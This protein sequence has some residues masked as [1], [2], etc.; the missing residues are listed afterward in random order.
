MSLDKFLS[1]GENL[2]VKAGGSILT[3]TE[4]Y[5][6]LAHKI[7]QFLRNY[8]GRLYVVVSAMKNRT[9]ELRVDIAGRNADLLNI[10][11][12][13]TGHESTEYFDQPHIARYLINGEFES[14]ERLEQELRKIGIS[15]YRISQGMNCPIVANDS[16]LNAKID[17]EESKKKA[18]ELFEK[19]EQRVMIVPGF[20]AQDK[21]GLVRLLGRNSSD[22]V[23]AMMGR[24]DAKVGLVVYL[25]DIDGIFENYGT[26]EQ[27][28]VHRMTVDKF[29]K[30]N[31]GKI[32]D[33]RVAEF[34]QGYNVLIQNQ[35]NEWGSQGTLIWRKKWKK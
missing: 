1:D 12:M 19:I 22:I 30:G 31:Y 32:L 13:G 21:Y 24:L 27:T 10:C 35:N 2:V 14:A 17:L 18:D 15:F 3:C 4:D 6:R 28:F 25:K 23:A 7:K 9:D 33:P 26:S 29:K 34:I 5:T 11:L 16:Y 20:G 8:N